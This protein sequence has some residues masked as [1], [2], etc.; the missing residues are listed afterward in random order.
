HAGRDL[1]PFPARRSSDLRY[2]REGRRTM[3][4]AA[5]TFRAAAGE[6]LDVWAGRAGVDIVGASS[7]GA[8][9]AAVVHDGLT[10]ARARGTDVVLIDRKSTRLNSSHR[11][12]SY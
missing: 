10:A 4:V 7:R 6:Q 9:P 8:D 5:D 11:T 2:A 3:L 12:S 1:P